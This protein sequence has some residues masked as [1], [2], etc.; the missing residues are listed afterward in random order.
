MNLRQAAEMAIEA[1][2]LDSPDADNISWKRLAKIVMAGTALMEA[3]AQPE[4]LRIAIDHYEQALKASWTEGAKGEAFTHWNEARKALL[5]AA[6][7]P[8]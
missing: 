2:D 8:E 1:M 7:K 4:S 6:H 3:L 5:S